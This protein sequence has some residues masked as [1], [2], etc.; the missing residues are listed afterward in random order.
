ML[1]HFLDR[2]KVAASI[3]PKGKRPIKGQRNCSHWGCSRILGPMAIL[4]ALSTT[5]H[6]CS[7]SEPWQWEEDRNQAVFDSTTSLHQNMSIDTLFN[8]AH[9]L[10]LSVMARS[11]KQTTPVRLAEGHSNDSS[12]LSDPPASSP[13]PAS[14]PAE[15]S[16]SASRSRGRPPRSQSQSGG[17]G[18]PG[19]SPLGTLDQRPKTFLKERRNSLRK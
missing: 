8:H 12:N 17:R 19:W 16:T 14:R 13:P 6:L 9:T 5:S 2:A 18:K 3:L 10:E 4:T 1:L 7:H 11:C 15:T